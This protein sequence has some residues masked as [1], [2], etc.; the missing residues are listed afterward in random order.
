MPEPIPDLKQWVK[1]L[2][3]Q[4]P[5]SERAWVELSKDRW[6]ARSHGLGKD[7]VMRA[8]SDGEEV[9]TLK[10]VKE[11]KRKGVS[12]SGV[13]SSEV[14]RHLRDEPEE[15][16][17]N[18]ACI[19][20]NVV[21]QQSS[22]LVKANQGTLAIIPEKKEAE[23]IPSRAKMIERDTEG[24]SSRAV[25]DISRDEFGIVDIGGSPQISDAMI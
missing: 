25:E 5:Y 7:V 10:Q 21:I 11:R 18:L 2:V 17:D 14:S 12:G 3:L 1:S 9:P 6:E 15:R 23:I 13:M 16:E 20:A 8:P 24:G 4:R 19:R 22:N